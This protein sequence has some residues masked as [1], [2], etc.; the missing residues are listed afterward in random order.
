VAVNDLLGELSRAV[1]FVSIKKIENRLLGGH[2]PVT[3]Q[4]RIILPLECLVVGFAG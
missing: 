4:P 1:G 3:P 2:M